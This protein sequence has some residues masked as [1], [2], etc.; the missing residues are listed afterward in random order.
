MFKDQR[1]SKGCLCHFKERKGINMQEVSN[2]LAA[3]GTSV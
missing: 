3:F 1:L 2:E